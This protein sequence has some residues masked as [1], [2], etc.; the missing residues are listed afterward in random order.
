MSIETYEYIIIEK[1][2]EKPKTNVYRVNNKKSNDSLGVIKWFGNWR[3][4]CFF[5][6]F[7]TVYSKGCLNDIQDFIQKIMN[8]RKG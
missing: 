3:Q 6:S 4:Y 7:F 8:E 1:I 5:P 2:D